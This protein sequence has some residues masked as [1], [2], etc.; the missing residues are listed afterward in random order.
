MTAVR[1]T[2]DQPYLPCGHAAGEQIMEPPGGRW[3]WLDEIRCGCGAGYV[4]VDQDD[5]GYWLRRD[6]ALA[7]VA[8]GCPEEPSPLGEDT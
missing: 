1:V 7:L 2:V 4:C 8:D 5:S 6:D 3:G